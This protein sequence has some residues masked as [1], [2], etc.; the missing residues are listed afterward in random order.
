MIAVSPEYMAT[1][2]VRALKI[3]GWAVGRWGGVVMWRCCGV[4]V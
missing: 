4:A 3:A 2:A 1:I